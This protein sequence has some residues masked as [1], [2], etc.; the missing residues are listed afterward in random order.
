MKIWNQLRISSKIGLSL[1]VIVLLLTG[2]GG[3]SWLNLA[4]I[5]TAASAVADKIDVTLVAGKSKTSLLDTENSITTSILTESDADLK[6]ANENLEKFKN[7]LK[8]LL[9][10]DVSDESIVSELS[11]L[12][13]DYENITLRQFSA[14]IERRNCSYDFTQAAT[15]VSTTT[16]A[17]LTALFREGRTDSLPIGIKLNSIP[18]SGIIAV[19][20]YL[21]TRNPAY[22]NEAKQLITGLDE[23]INNLR[24]ISDKSNRIQR[25]L[26]IL[27]PQSSLYITKI[28]DLIAATNQ[29][30]KINLERKTISEKILSKITYLSQEDVNKQT[31]SLN[32][33]HQ[34][35]ASSQ[36]HIIVFSIIALC[37]SMI[38]WIALRRTVVKALLRLEPMM[39]RLANGDLTV[40]V[41]GKERFD[42]LGIMARAVQVF[43][44]NSIEVERLKAEQ[45]K[46][47]RES[48]MSREQDMKQLSDTFESSIKDVV[49][50]VYS[51]SNQ[52]QGAAQIMSENAHKTNNQCITVSTTAEQASSTVKVVTTSTDKLTNSIDKIY[53]QAS[54]SAQIGSIAVKEA[55]SANKTV[56]TLVEASQKIGK[57]VQFIHEIASQTSLLALNATIEAVHAGQA[58]KGFAIVASEVKKL[59]NRTAKATEDIQAQVA[60][61]QE[62]TGTTA[63]AIKEITR[64]ISQ[65]GEISDA[66]A[67]AVEEQRLRTREIMDNVNQA[68][69]GMHEVSSNISDV[70]EAANE[71]KSS[72]S[73]ILFAVNDLG[74][75]AN[76]LSREAES[77]ISRVRCA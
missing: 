20:R 14:I 16:T 38:A 65:M 27:T 5:D 7:K 52:L 69:S 72:A 21:A 1:G 49:I 63:I 50:A 23:T 19:G 39:L 60:Q 17:I 33:M 71:T 13:R 48:I 47:I 32:M 76:R 66:I 41:P 43:K 77:F 68:A 57:I 70:F 24:E 37:V 45:I 67:A 36:S 34:L 74:V 56:G 30:S 3:I 18:Q 44:E 51:T 73:E 64:T 40:D 35:V 62:A 25:F 75:Q 58:G 10:S 26:T 46:H 53:Y 61:M 15:A 12:Y 22:A 4:T 28:D 9:E 31:E 6:N 11:E 42:E 55:E 29:L 2:I 54:E 8:I 59:A